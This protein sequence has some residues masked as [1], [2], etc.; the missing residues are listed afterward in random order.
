MINLLP[1]KTRE[2]RWIMRQRLGLSVSKAAERLGVSRRFYY[3]WERCE[4]K[5]APLE[6]KLIALYREKFGD[7]Q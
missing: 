2:A 4:K 6:K 1:L 3:Y 5:S 7:N